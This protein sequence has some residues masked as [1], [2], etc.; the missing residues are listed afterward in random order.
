MKRAYQSYAFDHLGYM[1]LLSKS[2]LMQTYNLMCGETDD[3]LMSPYYEVLPYYSLDSWLS[4]HFSRHSCCRLVPYGRKTNS[5]KA[6]PIY[7]SF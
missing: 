4:Q 5:I 6:R 7:S 2:S 1:L 3:I